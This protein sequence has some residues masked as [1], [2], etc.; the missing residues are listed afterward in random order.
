MNLQPQLKYIHH[1]N[2][3]RQATI[4]HLFFSK[5][6]KKKNQEK[7][8]H[9][10]MDSVSRKDALNE[11]FAEH[12]TVVK[13]NLFSFNVNSNQLAQNFP[14]LPNFVT[15]FRKY[16]LLLCRFVAFR[17]VF[18]WNCGSSCY[19]TF[20]RLDTDVNLVSLAILIQKRKI[21]L[22]EM[23]KK[24]LGNI[25]YDTNKQICSEIARYQFF[26]TSA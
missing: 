1:T 19:Y 18:G 26:E 23:A 3:M 22:T 20:Q 6:R 8:K 7:T 10:Y 11:I 4:E 15:C 16:Q 5:I 9:L 24:T 14:H 2:T 25:Q 13:V 17:Y 12:F 21:G